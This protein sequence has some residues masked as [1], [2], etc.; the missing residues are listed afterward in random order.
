M[1]RLPDR[2]AMENITRRRQKRQERSRHI[3]RGDGDRIKSVIVA[4]L[5]FT[6]IA[7]AVAYGAVDPLALGLLAAIMAV[8]IM[9]WGARS[10]SSGVADL[11]SNAIQLPLV[12]MILIGIIQ[13]LPVRSNTVGGLLAIP[14]SAA[15]SL[16]A[17]ATRLFT[18]RLVILAVFFAAALTF[19]DSSRKLE[20]CAFAAIIFGAVMA[21]FGVI[22]RLSGA[23]TIYGLRKVGQAIPFG[24][25]VNQHHFAAF[26]E[27]TS[28]LA[29][30]IL[31][32]RGV[33]S[34]KRL[35][36]GIGAA[37]M[38]IGLI[39]TGSR[40]GLLGYIAVIAVS[41]ILTY[42][43]SHRGRNGDAEMAG[44]MAAFGGGAALLVG[45]IAVAF[46]LG[47]GG[48]LFRGIGPQ[49]TDITSGRTHFWEIA[50]QIFLD[51]PIIGAGYDAFAVAFTRYDTWSGMYR[52]EQ[53]H[54]DYL[55]TLSD[56]GI[57]GFICVVAF[58]YFLVKQSLSVISSS[59]DELRTNIAIGALA[60]CAGILIHSL[61][62]FP[63]R[64]TSNALFFLLL[65]VLATRD[66]AGRAG[67]SKKRR[68]SA[69]RGVSELLPEQ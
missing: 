7:S 54:N 42:L 14:A 60:G 20:R 12:G 3:A 41:G 18:I 26:M 38:G 47:G 27:M 59:I 65:V 9:L 24:P 68:R 35:F 44:R 31:I 23:E 51:H 25:F 17:Y 46:F 61:F 4:V 8:V 69:S 49:G 13:L 39:Y 45:V 64:T 55:Q 63:L 48:A 15:I 62:D 19:L 57:A 56:S 58:I 2:E 16:D 6:A 40:G 67:D 53:A 52:V 10:W 21:F 11:N 22:Q 37:F 28:G 50:W 66:I 1:L 33:G 29:I 34:T 30:G 32:G 43:A 36:A 5:M